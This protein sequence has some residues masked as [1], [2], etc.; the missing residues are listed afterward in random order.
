MNKDDKRRTSGED[1]RK[2]DKRRTS[3]E[4]KRK[5]DKRRTSGEDKKRTSG[6]GGRRVSPL[7]KKVGQPT[8]TLYKHDGSTPTRA[9]TRTSTTAATTYAA[10]ANDEHAVQNNP[11]AP[12]MTSPSLSLL[13]PTLAG[14]AVWSA[15]SAEGGA[16]PGPSPSSHSNGSKNDFGAPTLT[17]EQEQKLRDF[18][19]FD[20]GAGAGAAG[21]AE[22]RSPRGD[23]RAQRSPR[24]RPGQRAPEGSW[25]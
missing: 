9:S 15:P 3:G 1:K 16:S 12:P 6:E 25:R 24:D 18:N 20:A 10:R 17:K 4:D 8:Q 14:G 5:E 22:Q 2:E 11:P 7:G 23:T 19:P 13:V 21:G